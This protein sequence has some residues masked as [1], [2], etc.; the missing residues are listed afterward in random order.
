MIERNG[1]PLL[2]LIFFKKQLVEKI[3]VVTYLVV[4]LNCY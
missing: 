2:R 4:V 3:I 1:S